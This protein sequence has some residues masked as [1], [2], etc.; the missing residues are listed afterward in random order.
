MSGAATNAM[1]AKDLMNRNLIFLA[2]E[3]QKA[4]RTKLKNGEK[5]Q[6]NASP[7]KKEIF[8]KCRQTRRPD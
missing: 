5:L 2:I 7:D 1:T 4:L 6:S 3:A 8:H